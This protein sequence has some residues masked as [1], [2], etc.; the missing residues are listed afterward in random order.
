[1]HPNFEN[2]NPGLGPT[3]AIRQFILYYFVQISAWEKEEDAILE[4]E[5]LEK[6]G[7]AP[8]IEK[9]N[10]KNTTWWR[11]RLAPFMSRAEAQKVSKNLFKDFKKKAWIGVIEKKKLEVENLIDYEDIEKKKKLEG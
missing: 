5:K 4:F 8:Y 1:M 11:V 2:G 6:A 10:L 7:Y 3:E 9:F